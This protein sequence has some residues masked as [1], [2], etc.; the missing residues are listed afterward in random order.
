M[1]KNMISTDELNNIKEDL[2]K[3][4]TKIDL[5]LNKDYKEL[6]DDITIDVPNISVP[7]N[8]MKLF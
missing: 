2:K 5:L 1:L 6:L 4:P 3:I 7:G 8:N